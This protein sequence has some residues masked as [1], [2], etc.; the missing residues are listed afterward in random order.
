MSAR[1]LRR[2]LPVMA[3]AIGACTFG[4]WSRQAAASPLGLEASFRIGDAEF[5]GELLTADA[6]GI[7]V[8]AGYTP[9]SA[10]WTE[11]EGFT[12]TNLGTISFPTGGS[13]SA[14]DLE[15]IRL[16]ARYPWGL[17]DEQYREVARR[18]GWGDVRELGR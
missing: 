16:A 5:E 9:G 3:I 14:E 13:P 6:D 4:E 12:L 8:L 7:L 18:S 11:I 1:V 17:T 10:A 15:R 2:L